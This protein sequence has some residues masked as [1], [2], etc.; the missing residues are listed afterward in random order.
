M[1]FFLIG[2]DLTIWKFI[3]NDIDLSKSSL[4]GDS[5]KSWNVGQEERV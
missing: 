2:G 4:Y 5:K 1:L 3:V